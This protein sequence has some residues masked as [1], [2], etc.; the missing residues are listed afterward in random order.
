MRSAFLHITR[1]FLTAASQP[2]KDNA[3]AAFIRDDAKEEVEARLPGQSRPGLK[4]TGSPGQGNWAAVPWIAVFNRAITESAT[5]GYYIVYL[6]SADMSRLYLSLNQGTT[7]VHAEFGKAYRDEL[8]RR[9]SLARS[10][11]QGHTTNARQDDIDLEATG[12]LPDGYEAGHI[13]GFSYDLASLPDD[14]QLTTDLLDVLRL[15]LA[16]PALGGVTSIDFE[17]EA[18]DTPN[19]TLDERRRYRFH[20][21]IERNPKAA[22][23]VKQLLGVIC[24]G[25]DFNFGAVYGAT[26]QDYIEAHHLIPLSS[27]PS[28]QVVPMDPAKDFAVLCANCHRMMHRKGGPETLADLRKLPGLSMIRKAMKTT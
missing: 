6:F 21:S 28:D 3:L 12:T 13:L 27:L 25:C 17:P 8:R 7:A 20:R 14:I 19:E 1:N 4:V 23:K 18:A 24:Q 5:T 16:L 15:Y 11:L 2:L 26:G 10:R 9:A 22:K